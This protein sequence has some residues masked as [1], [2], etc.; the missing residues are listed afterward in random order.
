MSSFTQPAALHLVG[1]LRP[2]YANITSTSTTFAPFHIY[3]RVLPMNSFKEQDEKQYQ[4]TGMIRNNLP[5]KS[6]EILRVSPYHYLHVQMH[7]L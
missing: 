6:A 4:C 2:Q 1:H 5:T 3:N 7:L